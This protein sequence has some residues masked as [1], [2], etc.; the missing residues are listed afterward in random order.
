MRIGVIGSM[1]Y[2]EKMLEIRDKL[3]SMGHD[4][5]EEKGY[6]STYQNMFGGIIIGNYQ[7]KTN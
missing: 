4:A 6:H 5:L 2:T 1:Q 7:S 3:I